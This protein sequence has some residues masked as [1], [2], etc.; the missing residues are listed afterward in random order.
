MPLFDPWVTLQEALEADLASG[1][2]NIFAIGQAFA[3]EP[4]AP[5]GDWTI[6]AKN[7]PNK[8]NPARAYVVRRMAEVT[9]TDIRSPERWIGKAIIEER[10]PSKKHMAELR[11]GAVDARL[12][13][14]SEHGASVDLRA[15]LKITSEYHS[16]QWPPDERHRTQPIYI[17]PDGYKA[18]KDWIFEEFIWQWRVGNLAEATKNWQLAYFKAINIRSGTGEIYDVEWLYM[19]EI[20]QRRAAAA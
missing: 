3:R 16:D 20:D 9:K 6:P 1:L 4:K 10:N 15:T 7:M 2:T 5:R 18:R 13:V 8:R 19:D 12:N 14:L 17:P 11:L